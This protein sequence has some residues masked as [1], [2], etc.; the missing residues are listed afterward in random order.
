M[1]VYSQSQ[2][3]SGGRHICDPARFLKFMSL[4]QDKLKNGNPVYSGSAKSKSTLFPST[5]RLEM[6]LGSREHCVCIDLLR[7]R[8]QGYAAIIFAIRPSTL[9][10]TWRQHSLL[11]RAL[12]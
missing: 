9:V 5:D 10:F 2:K 8:E 4:L 1:L 6:L 7:D 3:R 11:C 12:Y